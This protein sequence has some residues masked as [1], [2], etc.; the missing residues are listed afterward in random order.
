MAANHLRL[1]S[2]I[3]ISYLLSC[4]IVKSDIIF[5][6][7]VAWYFLLFMAMNFF[8][9]CESAKSNYTPSLIYGVLNTMHVVMYFPFLFNDYKIAVSLL[10]TAPF[11]LKNIML[12]YEIL[13]LGIGG[14]V[15]LR[16]I[17]NWFKSAYRGNSANFTHS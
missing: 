8:I 7:S 3:V 5:N 10:Y 12:S 14:C 6:F 4:V 15:G 13:I 2:L 16:A 1:N 11:S 17:Y 9:A